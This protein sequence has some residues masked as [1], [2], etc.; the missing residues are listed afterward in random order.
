MKLRI[1]TVYD[2]KAEAF[3]PPF[4]A[5]NDALAVR[6]CAD[7]LKEDTHPFAR[8]PDD[9]TL[10]KLGEWDDTTAV[11]ELVTP[12]RNLGIIGS[13]GDPVDSIHRIVPMKGA[14]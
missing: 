2:S 1:Y 13:F 7:C 9:Y 11:Y 10:F 12:P 4:N 14:A 3:L 6:S 8:H 5:G